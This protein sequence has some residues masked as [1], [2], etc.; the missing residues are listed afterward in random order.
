MLGVRAAYE[1][2][3]CIGLWLD[4]LG[5]RARLR[6]NLRKE[7]TFLEQFFAES[8]LA[9]ET[10]YPRKDKRMIAFGDTFYAELPTG[11]AGPIPIDRIVQRS[12]EFCRGHGA[13]LQAIISEGLVYRPRMTE[14]PLED[15]LKAG[16]YGGNKSGPDESAA[17]ERDLWALGYSQPLAVAVD[18]EKRL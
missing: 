13:E 9:V 14:S 18:Y 8:R 7:V 12:R 3:H 1:E 15:A 4:V 10:I 5:S 6:E 2:F 16:A 11:G 17:T